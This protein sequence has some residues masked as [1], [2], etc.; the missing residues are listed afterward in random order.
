MPEPGDMPA[1]VPDPDRVSCQGGKG[2][3]RTIRVKPT[4]ISYRVKGSTLTP[5][6]LKPSSFERLAEEHKCLGVV[7]HGPQMST[8]RWS[9]KDEEYQC[10]AARF[11]QIEK[12]DGDW[13]EE[14]ILKTLDRY[15]Q[16]Q[17]C[18]RRDDG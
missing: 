3:A 9:K 11:I 17:C 12:R 4:E 15:T 8:C 16:V 13:S 6:S 7:L 10:S 18:V 1:V 5:G 2:W 14:T